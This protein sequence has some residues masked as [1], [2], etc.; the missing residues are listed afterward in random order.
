MITRL[1][2]LARIRASLIT[3]PVYGL[4]KCYLRVELCNIMKLS[5]QSTDLFS[6]IYIFIR[7][8]TIFNI[9]TVKGNAALRITQDRY[10]SQVAKNWNRH[11]I[12]LSFDKVLKFSLDIFIYKIRLEFKNA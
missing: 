8:L 4:D 3:R 11:V 2:W 7:A 5:S 1:H 10:K 9:Y 12:F 6:K